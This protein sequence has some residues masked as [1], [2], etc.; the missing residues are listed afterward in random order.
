M[1]VII[2]AG[3]LGKR[4][5]MLTKH[6]PKALVPVKGLPLIFHLFR[7]Y[8][9]AEFVVVGDYKHE[10]L[11]RYLRTF[12]K[13]VNYKLVRAHGKGNVAGLCDALQLVPDDEGV[14]LVWCDLLLAEDFVPDTTV[15]GC[16]VG[17]VDFPCSWRLHEG[18]LEKA[19]AAPG[20]GVAGLFLIDRAS[21]LRDLP[22]EQSPGA[23]G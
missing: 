5:G 22:T 3:G 11:E 2:Q 12:A 13:G 17:V 7:Q 15:E 4:M 6:K 20:E 14:M 16:Q 8:A 10:V 18:Q 23:H 9:G 21:R 19:P 1:V